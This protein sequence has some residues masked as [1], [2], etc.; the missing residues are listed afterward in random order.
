MSD[1]YGAIKI[2]IE[3]ENAKKMYDIIANSRICKEFPDSLKLEYKE[4]L[5]FIEEHWWGYS[6]FADMV[7]PFLMGDDYYYIQYMGHENSWDTNDTEGKY[8]K[9][10]HMYMKSSYVIEGDYAKRVY[11]I[12]KDSYFFKHQNTPQACDEKASIEFSYE[13][14][15]LRIEESYNY[16]PDSSWV[17]ELL[18]F[19]IGDDAF[20]SITECGEDGVASYY[21]IND[22][23]G[24]YFV[25][26]SKTQSF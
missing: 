9:V 11:P 5:L 7:M 24:K 22:K 16:Q 3:G 20:Y 21:E 14:D 15:I 8:F 2:A 4:N 12:L 23:E 19:E 25:H 18:R 1:R 6:P 17:T 10:P 26:P 13:N